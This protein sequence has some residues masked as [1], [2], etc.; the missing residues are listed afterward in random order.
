[1]LCN[2]TV[3]GRVDADNVGDKL[4]LYLLRG[5]VGAAQALHEKVQSAVQWLQGVL[6]DEVGFTILFAGCDDILFQGSRKVY[7][8]NRLERLRGLFRER[9]TV[10]LS[11]GVGPS[12]EAALK[13]LLIAKLAGK[14]RIV[15]MHDEVALST[16]EAQ[17]NRG[18]QE[19]P[20][21][22]SS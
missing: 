8:R 10:T 7:D 16:T 14:D 13:N 17:N 5:E 20:R 4:E 12:L 3:Y 2:T 18:R 1:M 15:D 11:C 21:R 9:S 6:R 19:Q 22:L